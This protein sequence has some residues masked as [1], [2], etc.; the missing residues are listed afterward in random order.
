MKLYKIKIK[1]GISEIHIIP[2]ECYKIIQ[3]YS[4][5][6]LYYFYRRWRY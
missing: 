6:I 1:N 4:Y 2:I 5:I 3:Q